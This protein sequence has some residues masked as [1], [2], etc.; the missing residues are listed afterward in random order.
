VG[1]YHLALFGASTIPVGTGGGNGPNA[2]AAKTNAAST[3]A[4]PVDEAMF[5]VNYMTPIVGADLAYVN[6]GFTA[7]G[8]VTLLQY[9]RVRGDNSA[10]ALDTFRTNSAVGLHLGYFMGSHFSL[11]SD[12]HYQR[13][14]SHPTTLNAM[15]GEQV[16]LSDA[17]MDTLTVSAGLR[18][19]FRWGQHAWIRPGISY[20][21]GFD[22][23]GIDAPLI[24]AQ[25][26]AVQIDIPV[27]F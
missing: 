4:R 13:W 18:F 20:T 25:T 6:H 14:L 16:P 27:M 1:S 12:L 9:V 21:R 8:E 15:T 3:V 17:A 11:G 23:R 5:A 10:D 24:T 19:H 26:N 22:G 7:Q 2:R